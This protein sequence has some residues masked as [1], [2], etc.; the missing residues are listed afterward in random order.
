MI[1]ADPVAVVM[2]AAFTFVGEAAVN[3][4]DEGVN[5]PA[6]GSRVF[7]VDTSVVLTSSRRIGFN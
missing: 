5:G 7:G 4:M 6:K 1:S 3:V 2:P